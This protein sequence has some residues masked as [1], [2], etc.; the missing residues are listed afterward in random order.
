M[1]TPERVINRALLWAE[2]ARP[3]K[4]VEL[5]GKARGSSVS[6]YP[7]VQKRYLKMLLS[8]SVHDP[9]NAAYP[10]SLCNLAN[11]YLKMGMQ[12]LAAAVRALSSATISL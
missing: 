11:A 10:Q 3:S 5:S 2:P 6:M 1:A 4:V 12:R 9:C 8:K 7:P